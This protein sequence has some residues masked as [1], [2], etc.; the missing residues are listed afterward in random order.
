M[1][2]S[3]LQRDARMRNRD[4]RWIL[5]GKPGRYDRFKSSVP[6]CPTAFENPGIGRN[7]IRPR[8]MA[9]TRLLGGLL[10]RGRPANVPDERVWVDQ[11]Q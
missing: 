9:P 11:P 3:R 6:E 10:H 1:S 2:M 7:P 8:D 4:E 5:R